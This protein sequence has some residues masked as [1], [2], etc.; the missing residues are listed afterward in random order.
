MYTEKTLR[1]MPFYTRK[2]ARQLNALELTFLRL[3][4]MLPLIQELELQG[5]KFPGKPARLSKAKTNNL[6]EVFLEQG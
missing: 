3:K 5:E 6:W 2:F 1:Y 4:C